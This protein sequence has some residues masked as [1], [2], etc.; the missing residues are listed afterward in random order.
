MPTPASTP[1]IGFVGLGVMGRPMAANLVRAGY[2][3]TV[4][5]INPAAIAT[6]AELG[7]R[8]AETAAEAAEVRDIFITMVVND[9][10]LRANL[11]EPGE[12]AQALAPGTTVIGM[13][14]ISRAFAQE[15]A[16]RLDQRGVAYLDAPVSG[17]EVGAQAGQL[18][19]MAGGPDEVFERCRAALEVLGANIYHVG[20]HAGDGQAVKMINQ[21]MVC[22]HNAVAAEALTF[23]ARLGLDQAMLLDIIGHSAGNSWIFSN[24]GPRMVERT[25]TPPKSALHILVKDLGFVIDAADGLGH[26]LVLGSAAHQL[27]KMA[28]A[29]G[30][31]DL[32]DSI[33]IELAERLSGTDAGGKHQQ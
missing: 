23:G 20:K 11:F 15:A 30:L 29:Q 6:L 8:P 7:A 2:P 32:D 22:V 1:R 27:Y 17:G 21:L 12:A 10:Q 33:L 9:A 25:F 24:R 3:C 31:T 14:T 13:S 19:I 4:Y 26:P 28:A 5:D 16:A 18:S